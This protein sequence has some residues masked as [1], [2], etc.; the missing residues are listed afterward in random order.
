[1]STRHEAEC[2]AKLGSGAAAPMRQARKSLKPVDDRLRVIAAIRTGCTAA[3][4]HLS[5]TYPE[6]SCKQMPKAIE[7]AI[8]VYAAQPKE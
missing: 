3:D 8:R 1:M 7:A 4:I 6:C 5:C 2:G